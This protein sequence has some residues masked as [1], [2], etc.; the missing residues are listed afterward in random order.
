M[1][2]HVII[3]GRAILMETQWHNTETLNIL[4]IYAPTDMKE[5]QTFWRTLQE[6]WSDPE[7]TLPFPD[8]TLGDFNVTEHPLDRCNGKWD[9]H[10]TVESLQNLLNIFQASD[11]WRT[12]YP[13][14]QE[15]TLLHN[16]NLHQSR[17]DRI[18][19]A[20]DQL[21]SAHEWKIDDVAI[22]TDHRLVSVNISIPNTPYIGKGRW[23]IP[24]FVIGSR[25]FLQ[26]IEEIGK[27]LLTKL[28]FLTNEHRLD[29]SSA[30]FEWETFKI[31]IINIAKDLAKK[32]T[33]QID[34]RLKEVD[35]EIRSINADRLLPNIDRR[36][37]AADLSKE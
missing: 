17:L 31:D 24:N 28:E 11:G 4:N 5:S 29:H 10:E 22:P 23:S 27:P 26:K 9:N 2:I 1:N 20:E 19:I 16:G 25:K 18:Y 7:S 34:R 14:T 12:T 8:I 3:P 32:T 36:K 30:Q 35:A 13:T 15:F 21:A 6:K 37:R 33:S